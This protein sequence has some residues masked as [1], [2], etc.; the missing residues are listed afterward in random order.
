MLCFMKQLLLCLAL[1][2]GLAA[3]PAYDLLLKGGHVIDPKNNINGMLDVGIKDGKIA[4]VAADIPVLQATKTV[5]VTGF[6]V[7]PGLIDIHVHVYDRSGAKDL[8]GGVSEG[9]QPDSFSFRSGVTTM[10]DAGS[11]GS[12]DFPDFRRR[13]IDH[14]K[15]RVLAFLNI[16]GAGMG[17]GKEDDVSLLDANAA[18]K[19]A[20]DNSDIIVGF[21]SAHYA[22]KG[23]ESIDGATKAGRTANL[24]VMVDF[25]RINSRNAETSARCWRISCGRATFIRTVIP[26]IARSCSITVK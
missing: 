18:A 20:K 21:K 16:S 1:A 12:Q 13:V 17:V 9:V 11:S 4:R 8:V 24:P 23:W 2:G 10:V 26:G 7:T 14:A 19:T 3:Q 22:G 6:Y 15:T 5:N 25:G